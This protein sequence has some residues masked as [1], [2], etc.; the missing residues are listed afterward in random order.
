MINE[1]KAAS[2]WWANH[3]SEFVPQQQIAAFKKALEI[4]LAQRYQGHWYESDEL[5]GSAY[6]AII[7]DYVQTDPLL[8]KVARECGIDMVCFNVSLPREVVCWINPGVVMIKKSNGTP[9]VGKPQTHSY[10]IVA[11]FKKNTL[12][13]RVSVNQPTHAHH[14][15]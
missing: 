10:E 13:D 9:T 6:R 14:V 8:V 1:I 15:D 12:A 2:T 11:S 7:C 5:R 4:E 3:L